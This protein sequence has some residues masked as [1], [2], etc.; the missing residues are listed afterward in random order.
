MPFDLVEGLGKEGLCSKG[1]SLLSSFPF[2]NLLNNNNNKTKA[3]D[4]LGTFWV[5]GFPSSENLL[6][7]QCPGDVTLP[8]IALR[9]LPLSCWVVCNMVP[10][11]FGF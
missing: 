8:K 4:L 3:C 11:L 2:Q 6:I 1:H 7:T 5:W 9:S 10:A